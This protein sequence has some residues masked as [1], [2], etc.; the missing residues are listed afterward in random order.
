MHR[1]SDRR[2]VTGVLLALGLAG[3]IPTASAEARAGL[4]LLPPMPMVNSAA[5]PV[6]PGVAPLGLTPGPLT[7]T[8]PITTPAPPT[9]FTPPM[10]VP[11]VEPDFGRPG[12]H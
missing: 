3:T 2:R 10:A 12:G 5:G 6:V 8:A 1:L 4:V 9:T 11:F 7:S